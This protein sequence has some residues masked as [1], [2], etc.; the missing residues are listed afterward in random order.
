MKN[1]EK[2]SQ[3]ATLVLVLTLAPI[4]TNAMTSNDKVVEKA[5]AAVKNADADDW[6]TLVKSAQACIRK[7]VNMEEALAWINKSIAIDKNVDNL[8]LLGDYYFKFG[9]YRQ[10]IIS[11]I[12]VIKFG[13]ANNVNYDSSLIEEKISKARK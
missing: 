11:Y 7:G 8:E 6:Q 1:V 2:F 4:F 5:R 10:A 3:M 12:E 13:H 9:N